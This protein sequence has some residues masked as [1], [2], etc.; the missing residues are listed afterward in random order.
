M[1][2]ARQKLAGLEKCVGGTGHLTG[3]VHSAPN[4][5]TVTVD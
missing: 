3:L 4:I 5:Q 1:L 2:N